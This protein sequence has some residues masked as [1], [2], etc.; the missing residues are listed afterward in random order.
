MPG[1]IAFLD[2]RYVPQA[3]LALPLNDAG[4][5]LGA[6]V[7]DLCRTFHHELFRLKD[8]LDRFGRSCELAHVPQALAGKELAGIAEQLVRVNSALA[9]P[10]QDL[11]LVMIAT[12]GAIGYY[13][14][15][16]GGAGDAHPTLAMHTFP[17]PFARYRRLFEEGAHLIVPAIRQVPASSIDPRI[18]QRSRLHWWL[19]ERQARQA[20]PV[21]SAILL[22][23][24]GHIMETAAANFLLVR[25]DTVRTPPRH[26]VLGGVSLLVTEELCQE[27]GIRFEER[28]LTLDDCLSADEAMLSSTPFCLAGV[29]RINNHPLPWP[30]P[31]FEKLSAAWDKKVGLDVRGQISCE[32]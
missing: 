31:V 7:T 21:A 6:T 14:G 20:D 13:A 9:G 32:R 19:A 8:H 22:D 3:E 27:C 24:K 11:A 18:K 17:L 16:E 10:E 4:F 26:T 12:P 30:G 5:V 2:D 1:P 15:Q 29:S 23:H 25:D 28:A